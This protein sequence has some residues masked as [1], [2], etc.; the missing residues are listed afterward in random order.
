MSGLRLIVRLLLR[1]LRSLPAMMLLAV[2]CGA[3]AQA[4]ELVIRSPSVSVMAGV[5]VL[6]AQLQFDVP[7]GVE[8]V[9]RD[10]ATLE[11]ALQVRFSRQRGWWRDAQLAELTQRYEL[12]YHTVSE[13]YLLR[14]LNS[15]AQSSYITLTE[16][17]VALRRIEQVPLL[18]QAL[19]APDE[20][21]QISLHAEVVVQ[22]IPGLL[23]TLLF[24]RSEFNRQSIWYSWPVTWT[25]S[26]PSK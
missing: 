9:I 26:P 12:K 2:L 24:W 4:D 8:A 22:S 21:N 11:L 3:R 14:N 16:A 17:L 5:Y 19:I 10:G 13:R 7:L 20:R 18:D 23:N 25:P 1:C 6:S 15:G